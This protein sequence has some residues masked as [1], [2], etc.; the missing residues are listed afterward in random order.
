MFMLPSC[1]P[2]ATFPAPTKRR[3]RTS[4]RQRWP[5][6]RCAVAWAWSRLAT[7]SSQ[8]SA[9][10]L[11]RPTTLSPSW[12]AT[13]PTS[14]AKVP[15]NLFHAHKKTISSQ[16]LLVYNKSTELSLDFQWIQAFQVN[17]G[18]LLWK[19]FLY[20]LLSKPVCAFCRASLEVLAAACVL[21]FSTAYS[22]QGQSV[23]IISPSSESHQQVVAVGQPLTAQPQG[24]VVVRMH[25]HIWYFKSVQKLLFFQLLLLFWIK[26]NFATWALRKFPKSSA[27]AVKNGALL[28]KT[29]EQNW[30]S[31]VLCSLN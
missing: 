21:V 13:P 1:F 28:S 27:V 5:W 23:Q 29:N 16:L 22:I 2:R 18:V 6:R 24:T 8:P 7:P 26:A 3:L 31:P 15:T 14:P 25:L 19:V 20:L 12:A 30:S 9:R 17:T 10:P 11:C 4:W